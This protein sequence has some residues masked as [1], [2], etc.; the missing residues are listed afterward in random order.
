[1]D[2]GHAGKAPTRFSREMNGYLRPFA[3][4]CMRE[5][6]EE[7]CGKSVKPLVCQERVYSSLKRKQYCSDFMTRGKIRSPS[8]SRSIAFPRL[9]WERSL[10]SIISASTILKRTM[11]RGREI[12]WM[13]GKMNGFL[14]PFGRP[15]DGALI[16]WCTENIF[17]RGSRT[18]SGI[19]SP[20]P[21][22]M[23]ISGGILSEV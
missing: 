16:S 23:N 20:I 21:V 3:A 19:S 9:F 12:R 1:M 6:M 5:Q 14:S 8:S 7:A 18:S 17:C 2:S 13:R 22:R 15:C 11:Q 10:E 4:S